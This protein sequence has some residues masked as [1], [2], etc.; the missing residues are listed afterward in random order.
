MIRLFEQHR[1]RK[2]RELDG[3]WD[4]VKEDDKRQYRLPVPGCWEQHP[5]MLTYRGV[6][7]YRKK[8]VLEKDVNLRLEWKGVSHTA[9][10]WLEG[11]KLTN[12]YNAYTPF[13]AVA[14]G[15]EQGE[16]EL[17]VRVD[18]RFSESSSLHIP[19]DYYT[20]GGIT[21][22]VA[23]EEISELFIERIH[24]TPTLVNGVWSAK[25]EVK[26]ANIGQEDRAF[27]LKGSLKEACGRKEGETPQS[28]P[29]MEGALHQQE[30]NKNCTSR[31][32]VPAADGTLRQQTGRKDHTFQ[33]S[34]PILEG[35]VQAGESIT[36]Q[37]NLQFPG[38]RPWSPEEPNLYLLEQVLE[39][40]GKELDDL[41][42][43]VGFRTV[44]IEGSRLLLNGKPIFLKGFNRHEDHGMAG[45]A[46]PL[47]L[48]V[49]DMELM[50]DMG[51][52]AVRTCHY[53]NDE[54]FLDL[55]DE[56]GILVWEE[57]HARGL[58]EDR[59]KNPNFDKQC[60]D[61]IQEMIENHY[62]HPAIVIWGLLNE[63][64]S[65][66]KVGREKYQMK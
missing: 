24:F 22:P 17:T 59:M 8:I 51:A 52:N 55:C 12:H 34:L 47:Q 56:R 42:E 39:V 2:V 25:I 46:I 50:Q 6:G 63:C 54:R 37:V 41:T 36:L 64:A 62:N 43:R 20:Y 15:V 9:E 18:N 26:V 28:Q 29:V 57:N 49:Q 60:R 32:S 4:F 30:E 27:R 65:D 14:A 23:L 53:P 10:V 3:M 61:C 5:D 7:T 35:N 13:S 1:I 21:R 31:I 40:E 11:Q 33:I 58:H 38:I 48:M 19:N 66:T 44:E 16:H 45:C